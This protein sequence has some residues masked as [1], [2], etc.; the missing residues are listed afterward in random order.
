MKIKNI[1]SLIIGVVFF[2]ASCIRD[3]KTTDSIIKNQTDQD[4]TIFFSATD[5]GHFIKS[6][7][8]KTVHVETRS[9][10]E[11]SF[12]FDSDTVRLKLKG[13]DKELYF[14]RKN[15]DDAYNIFD[16]YKWTY[17]TNSTYYTKAT[18]TFTNTILDNMDQ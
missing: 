11:L 9:G 1:L 3:E 16:I 2:F 8:E 14:A 18:Y 12:P 15:A 10:N 13:S 5:Q 6:K 17:L 7:D 4:F